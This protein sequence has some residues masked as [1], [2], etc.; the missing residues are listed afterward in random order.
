METTS[1][2]TSRE[3]RLDPPTNRQIRQGQSETGRAAALG[4]D[5][6]RE[7]SQRLVDMTVDDHVVVFTPGRDLVHRSG[8]AAGNLPRRVRLP[9]LEPGL[10]LPHRWRHDEDIQALGIAGPELPGS[11]GVDVE[12]DVLAAVEHRLQ[13][14]GRCPV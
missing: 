14:A 4:L 7:L 8:E 5:G 6:A 1:R 13:R 12:Q 10:E 2:S 9:F 3:G 11:L